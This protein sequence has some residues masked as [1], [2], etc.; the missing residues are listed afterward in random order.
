MNEVGVDAALA[1]GQYFLEL[2]PYVH[3]TGDTTEW[4]RLSA[5]G[6]TF[7]TDVT[8]AAEDPPEGGYEEATVAVSAV[9]GVEVSPGVYS[10]EYQMVFVSASR[11]EGETDSVSMVLLRDAETWS[12]RGVDISAEA[13][14]A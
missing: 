13:A 10:L 3:S 4:R 2:F 7:C 8:R 6:C 5:Q 11:P 14:G 1:V 9:Q 12:V